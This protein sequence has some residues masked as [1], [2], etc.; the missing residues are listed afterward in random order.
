LPESARWQSAVFESMF[1][2]IEHALARRRVHR[3]FA[4]RTRD[5]ILAWRASSGIT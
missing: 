2:E 3:R 1:Y 5:E 4:R